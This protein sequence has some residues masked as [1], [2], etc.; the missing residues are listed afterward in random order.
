MLIYIRYVDVNFTF[1][2]V[3][4][5]PRAFP[6]KVLH[7][8]FISDRRHAPFHGWSGHHWKECLNFSKIAKFECDTSQVSEDIAPPCK[9]LL[10]FNKSLWCSNLAILLILR[11]I[12]PMTCLCQKLNK[13]R[14]KVYCVR[15]N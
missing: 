5:P 1:A 2:L 7:C 13:R 4:R 15:H 9:S 3:D 8:K 12:F 6:R 14:E 10:V 11:R